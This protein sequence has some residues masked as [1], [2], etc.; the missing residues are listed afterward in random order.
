[1]IQDDADDLF[2]DG[3]DT[4]EAVLRQLTGG[5][6]EALPDMRGRRLAANV[7]LQAIDYHQRPS[8]TAKREADEFLFSQDPGWEEMRIFWFEMA[9]LDAGLARRL[10]DADAC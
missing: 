3:L 1:M 4:I 7:L 6:A 8:G 9:G 2:D 5:Q 10:H